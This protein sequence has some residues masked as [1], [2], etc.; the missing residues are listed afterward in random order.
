MIENIKKFFK[1]DYLVKQSFPW[2]VNLTTFTGVTFVLLVPL[3]I[4]DQAI[5]E[6]FAWVSLVTWITYYL[7]LRK[8]LLKKLND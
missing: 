7:F 5:R 8:K 2:A 3:F 1:D 4:Q 6:I